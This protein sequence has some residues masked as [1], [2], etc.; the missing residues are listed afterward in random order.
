MGRYEA[1]D[2]IDRHGAY[3]RANTALTARLGLSL[4]LRADVDN[5][6]QTVWPTTQAAL[7]YDVAPAHTIRLHYER[8]AAAPRTRPHFLDMDVR[9]QTL[10]APFDLVY[11]ARGPSMESPSTG[12]DAKAMPH[13]CSLV[14]SAL[15]GRSTRLLSPCGPF[16]KPLRFA[17]SGC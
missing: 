8:A 13:R 2:A 10:H 9:R 12:T 7:A 4:A 6:S 14:P 15:A 16:T 11:H 1:R 5:L 17:S 3:G